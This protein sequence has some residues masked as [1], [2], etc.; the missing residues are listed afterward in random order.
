LSI[1]SNIRVTELDF[2]TIKA[3]L[4]TFLSSKPEFTDYNFEGSGLSVLI[5]LLAYNT[6]YNAVIGN[7]L[8]QEMFLD[9]AVKKE[10]LSLI[11][12]RLGYTPKSYVAPQAKVSLEVFPTTPLPDFLTL[13]KN[14]RFNATLATNDI[15]TFI[16]REAITIFPSGG[17]YIFPSISIYEGTNTTFRYVVETSTPQRFVIPSKYVDISLLKVSVQESGT[18][19]TVTEFKR[20]ESITDV[21]STTNAY[22]VKINETLNY[23]VYFGDGIIGTELTNGNIVILDYVVTNGD[24]ANGTKSFTFADSV[25]GYSNVTTTL[26]QEA[27]GGMVSESN[28]SIRLNAQ[29]KVLTQDRAVTEK[30]YESIISAIYPLDTIAVFGGETLAN[31]I[32]GKV[33]IS[34]KLAGTTETLSTEQKN[35]IDSVLKKKSVLALSHEFLDPEYMYLIIDTKVKYDADRTVMSASDVTTKVQSN[36]VAYTTST[37]NRFNSTFEYSKLIGFIDN[38]DQSFLANDTKFYL[39]KE[40]DFIFGVSNQYVFDFNTS[41]VP[42][43]SK[44]SNVVSNKFKL[45]DFPDIDVYLT[46]SSGS[47]YAYQIVNNT[48]LNVKENIGT[49]D[50]N[51]GIITITDNILSSDDTVL[52]ITVTPDSKIIVPSKNNILVSETSDLNIQV[53][54]S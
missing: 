12:K 1:P 52:K 17:R 23:E 15:T 6:H 3:N 43:N 8:V 18:T 34:V 5:D 30:D 41:L 19:T 50:Y 36:I 53:N 24:L 11:A 46:D 25:N 40:I 7:M 51:A 9:T 38:I 31:P 16:N 27:F 47:I 22:F 33:F 2:D 44:T 29:A 26:I 10:S 4:K 20:Y 42:S 35:T 49:I 13:G 54:Q 14:A 48:R 32:Y 45:T 37:L 21:T 28:D 39:R